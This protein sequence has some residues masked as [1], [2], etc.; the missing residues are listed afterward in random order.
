MTDSKNQQ[1]NDN[2]EKQQPQYIAQ[3]IPPYYYEEEDEISLLD[4]LLVLARN[5]ML[6]LKTTGVFVLL[7]L[8]IAVFSGAEYTSSA[9]L[10]RET[11]E[12]AS[13][14]LGGLAALGQGLGLSI[15]GATE[16]LTAE[17]YPDILTSRE[18]RLAVIRNRYFF[19]DI[20]DSLTLTAYLELR[21]GFF[22]KAANAVQEYTI[23]LPGKI[24]SAIKGGDE[25][26]PVLTS[27]GGLIYPTEEEEDAM[28]AV[29]SWL[30]VNVDQET[31]IMSVSVTT[32]D[33]L[34]SANLAES[35][36]NHLTERVRAI[37]TQKARDNVEFIEEQAGI[38]DLEL[39]QAEEA[40]A[41]FEDRNQN[42]ST[43]R[44][45]T[46]RARYQRQV[47]FASQKF[48]DFQTQA[49]S[50]ANRTPAQ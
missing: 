18:V 1:N 50:G 38:A 8:F 24:L 2:Q 22:S 33:P 20:G 9:R 28:E 26:A 46:E 37:R 30:S 40:L 27:G 17:A 14:N 36:I 12:A 44:L 6:I 13:A 29:S 48:S 23:G 5:K 39:K 31:G 34:L 7:G 45:E 15:G 49:C 25:Y 32:H 16:G 42:I 35:F 11:T 43:S 3:P 10:I 4:M 41:E 19:R 47:N 21:K